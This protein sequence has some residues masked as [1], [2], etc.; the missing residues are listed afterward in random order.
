MMHDRK[1]DEVFGRFLP[2]A[3][4]EQVEAARWRVLHRVRDDIAASRETVEA[5]FALNH[6]DYYILLAL[7]D[8]E[9][10]A[11][12]IM[13]AVEKVTEGA[14]RFGPGTLFTSI[15]RLL[16][17]ALIEETEK[18]PDSRVN[19]ELRQYYRLTGLGQRVLAAEPERLATRL[20]HVRAHDV[21]RPL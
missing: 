18:R 7:E 16:N 5:T 8:G 20:F 13:S 4:P 3:S 14:T 17:A 6:G 1:M 12:A 9:R 15:S 19:D 11:Y 21:M 2:S 10:H